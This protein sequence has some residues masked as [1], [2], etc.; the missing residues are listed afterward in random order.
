MLRKLTGRLLASLIC[1]TAVAVVGQTV[2]GDQ[3]VVEADIV[4]SSGLQGG[5]YWS[6]GERFK[7]VAQEMEISVQNVASTGSLDNLNQLLDTTSPVNLAFAQADALQQYLK[8]NPGADTQL[9]VIENIGQECVFIV[10]SREARLLEGEDLYEGQPQ[11][12]GINSG[13]SGTAVTFAHMSSLVPELREVRVVYGDTEAALRDLGA[14]DAPVDAVMVVHRPKESSP[15]VDLAV[16]ETDR[17][18]FLTL[19]DERL[20][21]RP[22]G[23]ESVYRPMRLAMRGAVEPVETICVR[24]LLLGHRLK[25]SPQ[26]RNQL[27]DLVNYQWMRVYATQ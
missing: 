16:A 8:E 18:R 25:V 26:L 10:A 5:G 23:A 13:E 15:E 17:Y 2:E 12:L 7:S 22:S 9:E 27:T 1:L 3:A 14:P 6:A 20:T 19:D 24:G 11:R 21:T 4:I